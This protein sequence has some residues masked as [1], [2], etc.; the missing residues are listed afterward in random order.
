VEEEQIKK[1]LGT[2]IALYRKRMGLTQ[3]QLAEKLNY[4][5]KAVSK[6]ERGESVPDVVTVMQIAEALET[7]VDSL[8]QDMDALPRGGN[9]E[10]VLR[11]KVNKKVVLG[12]CGLLTLFTALVAYTVLWILAVPARWLAVIYCIPAVAVVWLSLLSA[13]HDFRRNTVLISVVMWGCILSIYLSLLV[14]GAGNIWMLFILGL[15]GQAAVL[16]WRRLFR[17]G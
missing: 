12:L 15:P 8:L 6:W 14:F 7:T 3:L 10:R 4:S 16:L 17:R 9:A 1:R 11:R 2:N 5:D 13:W